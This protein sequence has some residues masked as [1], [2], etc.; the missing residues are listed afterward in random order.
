MQLD[1][2]VNVNYNHK[3]ALA[4][5]RTTISRTTILPARIL[6]ACTDHSDVIHCVLGPHQ[7]KDH[8]RL[9]CESEI[10]RKPKTEKL[11]IHST[12]HIP[13]RQPTTI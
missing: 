2:L 3:S 12:S 7:S 10:Q 6:D 11:L 9:F 8:P 1:S 4:S 5:L 13:H